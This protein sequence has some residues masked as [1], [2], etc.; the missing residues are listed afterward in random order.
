MLHSS[1]CYEVTD[2]EVDRQA[3]KQAG[4]QVGRQATRSLLRE[5]PF[6]RPFCVS[7]KDLIKIPLIRR[8]QE[9]NAPPC[10]PKAGPYG[11][12]RHFQALLNI[13]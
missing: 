6:Y 3:G 9:R 8:P 12:R 7:L 11:N 10:S 5:I 4:R 1:P 13:S 2:R